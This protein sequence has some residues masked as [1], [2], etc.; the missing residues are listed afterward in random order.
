MN[1]TRTRLVSALL[2]GLMAL[3][4]ANAALANAIQFLAGTGALGPNPFSLVELETGPPAEVLIGPASFNPGLDFDPTSGLLYGANSILRTIDPSDGSFVDL[5]SID[6]ATQTDLLMQSIAFSPS[7]V[8]YGV[9]EQ[10]LYTIDKITAFAVDV[11]TL[12]GGV[13]D[14]AWGIDFA[15][16]GTLYGA[17][18][19]LQIIDPNTAGVISTIGS[20]GFPGGGQ[21]LDIDYA[22]DGN[23]YGVVFATSELVFIDKSDA[24]TTLLGTYDSDLWGLT[25]R[26]GAIGVPEPALLALLVMGLAGM[27]LTRGRRAA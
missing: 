12:P 15:P 26:G 16:D 25:S 27:G 23:L 3:A 13:I 4:P 14:A 5:G 8:L 24:N 21:M 19:S 20:F 6:S 2:Y 9:S 10:V 18:T 17:A 1:T 22:A 7:G 11:G